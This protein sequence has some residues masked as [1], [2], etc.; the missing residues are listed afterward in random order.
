VDLR[1]LHPFDGIEVEEADETKL[2]SSLL[3]FPE[4]TGEFVQ[5][6][7]KKLM[8]RICSKIMTKW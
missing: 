8:L 1:P 4:S 3:R 6:I 5:R 7:A 2:S